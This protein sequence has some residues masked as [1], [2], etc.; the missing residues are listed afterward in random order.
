MARR[1]VSKAIESGLLAPASG[2]SCVV[3]GGEASE[4]HHESYE[5]ERWLDVV[6]VCVPCHRA[7]HS[8]KVVMPSCRQ[9]ESSFSRHRTVD[10]ERGSTTLSGS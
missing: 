8:G 3:C 2:F 6:P 4:Y 7:I 10:S 9:S 5:P 1:A